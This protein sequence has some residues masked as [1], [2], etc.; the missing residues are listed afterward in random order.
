MVGV[1]YAPKMHVLA[2]Q[3]SH[4]GGGI[5]VIYFSACQTLH[6]TIAGDVR[7]ESAVCDRQTASYFA[8]AAAAA[9][10]A[11]SGRFNSP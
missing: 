7:N 2:L 10:A 3:L 8:A 5:I 1:K 9:A 6:V 4:V 11:R